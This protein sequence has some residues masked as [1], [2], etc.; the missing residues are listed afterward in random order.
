M[1]SKSFGFSYEVDTTKLRLEVKLKA[2]SL[3]SKD[4]RNQMKMGARNYL[5]VTPNATVLKIQQ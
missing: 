5:T 2:F 1:A 4:S 3:K